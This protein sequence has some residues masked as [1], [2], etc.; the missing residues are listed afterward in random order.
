MKI[1]VCPGQYL[2]GAMIEGASKFDVF[3]VPGYPEGSVKDPW[4]LT[5]NELIK[6]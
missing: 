3:V 1:V 6:E 4:D 2:I 5:A